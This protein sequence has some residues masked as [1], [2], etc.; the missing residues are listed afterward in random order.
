MRWHS[1]CRWPHGRRDCHSCSRWPPN[2]GFKSLLFGHF[3]SFWSMRCLQWRLVYR[4][5]AQ[6]GLVLE[7]ALRRQILRYLHLLF[8]FIRITAPQQQAPEL[9]MGARNLASGDATDRE[10]PRLH[11]AAP[12][13][14]PGPCPSRC[15]AGPIAERYPDCRDPTRWPEP[16][17]I[18]P[19]Y[20]RDVPTPSAQADR[21]PAL[22]QS[23]PARG[24]HGRVRRH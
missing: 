23:H 10:L 5:S 11:F 14:P 15:K 17:R 20:S 2:L 24:G 19:P 3:R 6:S 22:R 13:Q 4:R 8:P 18:P 12:P 1:S 21:S 9:I 7:L 16:D